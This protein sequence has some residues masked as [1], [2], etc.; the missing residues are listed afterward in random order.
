MLSSWVVCLSFKIL[1]TFENEKG[2]VK[3]LVNSFVIDIHQIDMIFF[4]IIT[5]RGSGAMRERCFALDYNKFPINT[6]FVAYLLE[7]ANLGLSRGVAFAHFFKAPSRGFCMK[8]KKKKNN[9]PSN[10]PGEATLG[11]D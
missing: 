8:K 7:N 1:N 11:I 9:C 3:I 2:I 6:T 4:A 10:A 5:T